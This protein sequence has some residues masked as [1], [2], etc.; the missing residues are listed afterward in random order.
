MYR[1]CDYNINNIGPTSCQHFDDLLS[2][3]CQLPE[4][5]SLYDLSRKVADE[6]ISS[7]INSKCGIKLSLD[8]SLNNDICFN[9]FRP[10]VLRQYYGTEVANIDGNLKRCTYGS[11][12]VS[13]SVGMDPHNFVTRLL[14]K[15]MNEMKD[16]IH[17]L[18]CNNRNKFNMIGIDLSE[19]LI[20]VPS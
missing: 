2:I 9:I 11:G 18:L 1:C 10:T 17:D 5:T 19:K 16:D 13:S 6:L 15:E 20:I 7:P 3:V 12:T 4:N 14:N 8:K